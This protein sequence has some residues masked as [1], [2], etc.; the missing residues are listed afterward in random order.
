MRAFVISEPGVA[1]VLESPPPRLVDGEIVVT[2]LLVGICGTDLELVDGTLDPQYVRYP[3]VL[4]HEWVGRLEH[5]VAGVGPVG[6]RV[7]VE[8]V[9]PC[10]AC[11]EC[12]RGATNL[13]TNYDEL[14]FTRAGALAEHVSVPERLVHALADDVALDDAVFVE[15][16]AVVWR[17]LTRLPLRHELRVAIIGD[18]TI[19]LLAAHLVRLFEPTRTIIFGQ[20]DE[21]RDLARRAGADDFVVAPPSELFDLVIEASGSQSGVAT[22]LS[23]GAR[24]AMV[25]LLG[26]TPHGTTVDLVPDRVVNND[27]IIQGSFSYTREAFRNVVRRVNAGELRPSFLITHRFT[28]ENSTRAIVALRVGVTNEPRGKVVIDITDDDLKG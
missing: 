10:D 2:P 27:V 6:T 26:L 22:A 5:D 23:H 12:A 16:M 11:A 8:G 4:G 24:G 9:V 20:R 7:V 14:G 1:Q 25:I 28:L 3:L 21:Q 17:A 19:A 13:C 15:P 18:G